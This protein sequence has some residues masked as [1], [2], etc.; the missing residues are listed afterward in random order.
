MEQKRFM[1]I[2]T[3]ILLIFRKDCYM[4]GAKADQG[5]ILTADI[6]KKQEK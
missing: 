4:M 6:R 5:P 1:S 3:N 2:Y